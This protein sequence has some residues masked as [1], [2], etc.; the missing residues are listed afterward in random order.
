MKLSFSTKGWHGRSFDDFCDIAVDLK[1]QGIELH[2]IHN[3]L[4]TQKDGAFHASA[5]PK[6]LRKL[7]EK[8]L[9]IP[10]I[11]SICNL[12]NATEKDAT[13]KEILACI[14][15]AN[16]L[17]IPYVRIK[18]YDFED[19]EYIRGVIAEILPIA[20]KN[21]VVLLLETSGVF[22]DTAK[23]RDLLDSF[24]SDSLAA[25][26]DMYAP[27]FYNKEDAETTIKNLGAYVKQ[28]HL[29]DAVKTDRGVEFRLLGEGEM[30]IA[31]MILALRSVNFD[32]FVSLEWVPEWCEE[33]DDLEIIFSQFVTYMK[34]FSDTSKS[35]NSLYFNRA[36]TGCYIWERNRLIDNTF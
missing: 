15:I 23:L 9:G 22:A 19:I 27:Y 1:F 12:A 35:D 31:D 21:E 11:D 20:E 3:E 14:E 2:N 6:T 30:P 24:A 17:H 5:A 32:G 36:H 10:C 16:N 7:Y 25:L 34:Q 8:K 4:F 26:W 28:V 33:I 13:L 29:K 18:A